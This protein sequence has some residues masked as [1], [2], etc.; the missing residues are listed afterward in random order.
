MVDSCCSDSC[1][2]RRR[3]RRETWQS[4]R[5][6]INIGD[7]IPKTGNAVF[8][9]HCWL[10]VVVAFT[11]V[12]RT[13]TFPLPFQSIRIHGPNTFGAMP[14]KNNKARV[15]FTRW[16]QESSCTTTSSSIGR[17]RIRRTSNTAAGRPFL[18][19]R[20]AESKDTI[21]GVRGDETETETETETEIAILS[22][23]ERDRVLSSFDLDKTVLVPVDDVLG[24]NTYSA[25]TRS[26]R[27]KKEANAN[28]TT[29]PFFASIEMNQKLTSITS[30]SSSTAA[31]TYNRDDIDIDIDIGSTRHRPKQTTE[32]ERKEDRLLTRR[33]AFR[34]GAVLTG[35]ALIT[36]LAH[37]Q[38]AVKKLSRPK[39]P[40]LIPEPVLPIAKKNVEEG[41]QQQKQKQQQQQQRSPKAVATAPTTPSAPK[42]LSAKTS[43]QSSTVNAGRLETVNLTRVASETN[44]NVTMNCEKMCVS[45]DSSNFTFNKVEKPKVPNWLPSFLAPKP[46]VLKKY[47]N[48]ELLIAATAAGSI[49]EI[50]RTSLLYPLSTIKIR[51]Q[52]D[53][54]DIDNLVD[55][56]PRPRPLPSFWEQLK[57]LGINIKRKAD[58]GD[59]Y[60]GISPTLL[61]SVP[62]TGIYY[63]VRDVTKRML[64]MTPLDSTWVA[65]GGALVGDVVSLCFRTPSNA[66][67]IRLQAQNE[68]TGDWLGDSFKR[69]PMVILTDLPYLLSKIVISKLFI[70]GSLSVSN[71]AEYAVLSALVAGFLTT[72]FDV[73]QTRILL[74]KRLIL[75]ENEEEDE[76]ENLL[77]EI[78]T[79]E[80]G[81]VEG[82]EAS[83]NPTTP[84]IAITRPDYSL[85][86]TMVQIT[87]E[88][89]GGIQN[90]FSGWLERVV[91][92]G[93]GRAWLEPIQLIEYIGIRDAILLEWF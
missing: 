75:S 35:T 2:R 7:E 57:T 69:L 64:Y 26:T 33:D 5:R 48:T 53:R 11:L 13:T 34:Y 83:E 90:L 81:L 79:G 1:R 71:Y 20:F 44:I 77:S 88:G 12:V 59:L 3:R 19:A 91:Y 51:L 86:Q 74:D 92:L 39:Y 68:T 72:P 10:V 41:N 78:G 50:G 85:L 87:K 31:E 60:A 76:L 37:T 6:K 43:S 45:V 24:L 66:L 22:S 52:A 54:N 42:P 30:L 58:D 8:L 23:S 56:G 84:D 47:S 4:R 67:A 25:G 46:Q 36:G 14:S 16:Q 38:T 21:D 89:E 27:T 32:K 63:G 73:A 80:G 49:C 61:V 82:E 17:D 40:S 18:L 62:A 93:I 9:T 15:H 28:A 65:L 29:V 70:Q 55:L